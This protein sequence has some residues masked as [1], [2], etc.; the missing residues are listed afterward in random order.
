MALA[1]HPAAR[2]VAVVA[3]SRPETGVQIKAYLSLRTDQR[4]SLI[5]LKQY[6]SERLPQY[7]IPDAFGMMDA[8]PRTSTDKIDYQALLGRD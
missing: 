7:M 8:L 5:E 2:E 1:A 3:V 6:C 4:P